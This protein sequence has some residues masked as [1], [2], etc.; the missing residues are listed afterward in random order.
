MLGMIDL[1]V[2]HPVRFLCLGLFC[3]ILAG[4][5]LHKL[6]KNTSTDAFIPESHPSLVSR[7]R[8]KSIFG[9]QDPLLISVKSSQGGTLT[10]DTLNLAWDLHHKL[11]ALDNVTQVRSLVSEAHIQGNDLELNIQP[12]LDTT[13]ADQKQ[14]DA[15]IAAAM[16]MDPFV[17]TLISSDKKALALVV[18]LLDQSKADESY[19][20]LLEVTDALNSSHSELFVAGQGA[21]GGYLS[22]YIDA[23]SRKMQPVVVATILLLLFLAFRQLKGLIGPLIVIVASAIGAVGTMAWL[24]VPYYAITSALPVVITAIAVADAIHV[25]TAYYEL[26]A[27]HPDM[28]QPQ[29][30]KEAVLDMSRPITLTTITTIAGFAGLALASIMPPVKFFGMFAALGVVIAWLFTMMVLPGLLVLIKLP[31]T[32]IFSHREQGNIIGKGLTRVALIAIDR[33]LMVSASLLTLLLVA[34]YGALN[35]KVDRAQVENFQPEE[36]IRIAHDHINEH[37]AGSAYL[38]VLVATEE[39]EGL[40]DDGVL[41]QV[42]DIQNF[43]ETIPAVA[44]TQSI[45]DTLGV[46]QSE[47]ENSAPQRFSGDPDSFA[48]YMLLYE[49]SAKP[50]NYSDKIDNQY[51]HLLIRAYLNTDLFSQEKQVVEQVEAYLHKLPPI[52]GLQLELTG[53]VNVDYHW[54]TRLGDSHFRSIAISL[55]LVLLFAS[56]LFKSAFYGVLCVTPVFFAIVMVYGVMG[57]TGV[58]LEPATSMFAAIAIGVGVD[59]SIHF[60][61]RLQLAMKSS[62]HIRGAIVAKFPSAARA[63]FF[64]AAALASGFATLFVSQLPTLQRFGLM[65]TLACMASFF[66]ALLIVPLVYGLHFRKSTQ[67]YQARVKSTQVS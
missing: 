27:K 30:V 5:G 1:A 4:A 62:T 15:V 42:N 54:M 44:K 2:R 40:L 47:L 36:P 6:V 50:S 20:Q 67:A 64:N 32:R 41:S 35:L 39:Q 8:V 49:A 56:L 43:L 13:V 16:E 51:Q 21:V 10:A 52:D 59:F 31:A 22:Q 3:V 46:L 24:N 66:A 63:C 58:F 7:D 65:I 26:K 55:V 61:E 12:L 60:V 38:D 45:M 28:P 11:S 33:P 53:R 9:L 18:E 37:Y 48:Q 17:D 57:W 23:D 14:A 34:G 29:L 25:L 19:L